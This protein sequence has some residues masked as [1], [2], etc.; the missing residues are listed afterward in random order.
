MHNKFAVYILDERGGD[1]GVEGNGGGERENAN[2]TVH[3][4]SFALSHNLDADISISFLIL[5]R[6]V[7]INEVHTEF[8]RQKSLTVGGLELKTVHSEVNTCAG[9]S[10]V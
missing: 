5:S 2:H 9:L 6:I 3:P 1:W 10:D 7:S 8:A 4:W